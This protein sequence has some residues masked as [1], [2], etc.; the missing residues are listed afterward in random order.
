MGI[1]IDTKIEEY[2]KL[3]VAKKE[4]RLKAHEYCRIRSI[5][6]GCSETVSP[7]QWSWSINYCNSCMS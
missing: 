4:A 7:D 5:C 3:G 1:L 6:R 2:V